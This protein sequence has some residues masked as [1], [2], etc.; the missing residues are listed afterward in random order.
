MSSDIHNLPNEISKNSNVVMNVN[1]QNKQ[2]IQSNVAAQVQQEIQHQYKHQQSQHPQQKSQ[3]GLSPESIHQ[4]V[5]GLQ[6]AGGGTA[7]PSRDIHTNTEHIVQ[8]EEIKPNFIP[9]TTNENYIENEEDMVSLIQQN[10]NSKKEQDRLDI[11]YN[12][13]QTPLLI[14]ILFFFFQLPYF[15]KILIKYMPSLF[16]RDGNPTF[17]GF[18]IK[19]LFFGVSFY[20]ITRLTKQLSEI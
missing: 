1:E 10:K 14:M 6:Q 18:F 15:N 17:S 2:S 5:Q 13:L 20:A 7:L 11:L 4:I 9:A 19:T 16:S 8:D 12:E 3:P